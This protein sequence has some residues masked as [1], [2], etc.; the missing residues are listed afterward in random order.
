M[1]SQFIGK[2]I[3]VTTE[4][5]IKNPVSF[6]MDGREYIIAEIEE[7]WPDSSFGRVPRDRRKWWQRRHRNYFRV[8]TT[9]DEVYEI[10]YDRGINLEHPQF[11]KWFLTR[12]YGRKQPD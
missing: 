6:V 12:R 3:K 11:K 8:R 5:E 2:D 4:G 9:D 1:S 10:Y 7:A